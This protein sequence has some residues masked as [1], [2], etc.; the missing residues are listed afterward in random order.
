MQMYERG[1]QLQADGDY[2]LGRYRAP[3][4]QLRSQAV[5]RIV[6]TLVKLS[7]RL[8]AVSMVL[9]RI[10]RIICQLHNTIETRIA[11]Q[12]SERQNVYE[13]FLLTRYWFKALQTS[14]LP[15]E[16][17]F[18][19][20]TVPAHDFYR[21]ESPDLVPRQPDF[22]V[23]ARS[24]RPNQ[25]VI[26]EVG[27]TRIDALS[28]GHATEINPLHAALSRSRGAEQ[29]SK[30]QRPASNVLSPLFQAQSLSQ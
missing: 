2:L 17:R 28:R 30:K 22:S 8:A 10:L 26:T 19:L 23:A 12:H 20:E 14:K 1:T 21:A 6:L 5:R 15:F 11:R 18:A 16:I 29:L 9:A 13:P 25:K 27:K 3:A 4:F 7:A 24:D